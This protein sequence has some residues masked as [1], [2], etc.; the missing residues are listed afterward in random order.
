MDDC[1]KEKI[2]STV[3]YNVRIERLKKKLTQD[4][5]SEMCGITQKYLNLI[6][7]AKVNPSIAVIVN[8]C[9]NL[10]INLNTIYN[11]DC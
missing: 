6:E 9:E 10:K 4:K 11:I 5:L 7:K 1:L 3:A 2:L 8:I